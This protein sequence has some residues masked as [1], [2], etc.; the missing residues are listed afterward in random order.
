MRAVRRRRELILGIIATRRVETQGELV[1]DL[2]AA[3]VEASQASVSRDIAALGLVKAAGQWAAPTR[4]EHNGN[5]AQER[6]RSYLL[7]T[8]AAGPNLLVLKTPPGEA[9]G[10]GLAF[11]HL[12]LPGVVGSVAGDDTIFVAVRGARESKA[13]KRR[14]DALVAA[15]GAG[16]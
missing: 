8:A 5:P 6:I 7:S 11:D 12:D 10:V 13:I 2:H 16:R 3:G 1:A 4:V 15:G 9:Q 14:L